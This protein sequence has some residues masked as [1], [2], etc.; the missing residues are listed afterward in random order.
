MVIAADG[1][2][3]A[4]VKPPVAST[5]SG[6]RASSVQAGPVTRYTTA[7]FSPLGR[8]TVR[9]RYVIVVGDC[10]AS[11]LT[12]SPPTTSASRPRLGPMGRVRVNAIGVSAA[13]NRSDG[14][15]ALTVSD[16]LDGATGV[17]S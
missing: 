4:E 8:R 11:A 10:S 15:P 14:K 3:T 9:G 7:S 17:A 2:V 13:M 5:F 16:V 12:S 1:L 6:T